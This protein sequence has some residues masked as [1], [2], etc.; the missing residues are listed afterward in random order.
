MDEANTRGKVFYE[1][2]DRIDGLN[3]RKGKCPDCGKS[4]FLSQA[5][6]YKAEWDRHWAIYYFCGSCNPNPQPQGISFYTGQI[7]GD[8]GEAII[9]QVE[10]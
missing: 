8:N 2:D 10:M 6:E 3:S 9:D 4:I 5:N 7:E 1:D